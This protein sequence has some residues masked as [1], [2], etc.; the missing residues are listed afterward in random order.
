MQ[1]QALSRPI[2]ALLTLWIALGLRAEEAA[3]LAKGQ[4]LLA[5]IRQKLAQPEAQRAVATCM[6][7]APITGPHRAHGRRPCDYARS[8]TLRNPQVTYN[9]KYWMNTGA[10]DGSDPEAIEGTSGLGMDQPS[11]DNWY[12]NNFFEFT[13][14][15]KPLLKTVLAEFAVTQATGDT[16]A[17]EV[18]WQT[19][20]ATV[21]L[22][23]TLPATATYLDVR[24]L[25]VAKGAPQPVQLGFR[26][27][28][29][30]AQPP[31]AR[32]AA[33]R[34]RDIAAPCRIELAPDDDAL[35][36]FD[37]HDAHTGCAI[38]F[39][40]R[41]FHDAVLD[42][43]DYGVTVSLNYAPAPA[44]DSGCVRLWEYPRTPLNSI[45]AEVFGPEP[46]R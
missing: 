38:R 43:G 2:V 23:V 36:L 18:R 16:A 11:K 21:T 1:V 40:D 17:G 44:L 32:R 4:A 46:A 39:L 15:G 5:E 42:L 3:R 34:D 25:V 35:V 12:D 20:E 6:L 10:L 37:E 33:F 45:M 41:H 14:G 24:C 29:G 27:Y 7:T 30:H 28:P 19:L 9:L 13:Y 26:A 22:A 31:R 8:L